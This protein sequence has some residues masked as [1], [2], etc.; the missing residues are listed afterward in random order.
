VG[1]ATK[2]GAKIWADRAP[3]HR[4]I[5]PKNKPG[6]FLGIGF[7]IKVQKDPGFA[8]KICTFILKP[9]LKNCFKTPAGAGKT[10]ITPP[11]DT[12]HLIPMKNRGIFAPSTSRY[13]THKED[14]RNKMSDLRLQTIDCNAVIVQCLT[15][16]FSR[17]PNRI[18]TIAQL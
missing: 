9:L 11:G 2:R 16:Y 7:K 17:L 3:P 8:G 14:V 10:S 12:S 5:Y 15:P 13:Q 1:F 4:G 6:V 18:L